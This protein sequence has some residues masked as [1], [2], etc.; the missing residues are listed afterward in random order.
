MWLVRAIGV[1]LQQAAIVLKPTGFVANISE[2]TSSGKQRENCNWWVTGAPPGVI[3][4]RR[5]RSK[6][7]EYIVHRDSV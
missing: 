5:M 4:F 7:N 6:L 2:I 1:A 3:L